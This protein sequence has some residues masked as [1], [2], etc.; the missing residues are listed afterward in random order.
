[1]LIPATMLVQAGFDYRVH[2]DS[3]TCFVYRVHVDPDTCQTILSGMGELH[4]EIIHERICKEFG[5][6]ADLGPLMIS[7]REALL[8]RVENR[9]TLQQVTGEPG[10]LNF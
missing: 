8:N 10:N 3:S 1:M 4:L 5:I 7:Y 6:D 9:H 2:V